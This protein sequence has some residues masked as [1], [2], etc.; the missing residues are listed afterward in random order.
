MSAQNSLN[1]EVLQR[2]SDARRLQCWHDCEKQ[3]RPLWKRVI[4][5]P[6]PCPICR[7]EG[8]K[9]LR[10][11]TLA[12]SI[13]C[14]CAALLLSLIMR[15]PDIRLAAPLVCIAAVITTA[16]LLG[17]AAAILGAAAAVVTFDLLLFPPVGCIRVS[18]PA[19]GL[20]LVVLAW[21]AIAVGLVTPRRS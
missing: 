21:S 9:S 5:R 14:L 16:F 8:Y 17:R 11:K 4:H 12:G 2:L 7:Q 1:E 10:I 3:S 18:E 13:F 15:N 6:R 19:E 20:A